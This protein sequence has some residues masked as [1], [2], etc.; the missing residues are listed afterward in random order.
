MM[1][2]LSMSSAEPYN[3]LPGRKA[4]IKTMCKTVVKSPVLNVATPGSKNQSS[5][6]EVSESIIKKCVKQAK[7]LIINQI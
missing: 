1:M 6:I 3:S 4:S 5:L 2:I 7:K